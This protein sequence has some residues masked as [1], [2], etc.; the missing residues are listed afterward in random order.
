MA[1]VTRSGFLQAMHETV[2]ICHLDIASAAHLGL[3]V[4]VAIVWLL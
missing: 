3:S 2:S 4:A 1:D